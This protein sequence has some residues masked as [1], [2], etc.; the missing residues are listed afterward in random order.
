MLKRGSDYGQFLE[1]LGARKGPEVCDAARRILDSVTTL[2]PDV[3]MPSIDPTLDLSQ[4]DVCLLTDGKPRLFRISEKGVL[5][6]YMREQKNAG[7][8]LPEYPEF[9]DASTLRDLEDRLLKIG[10]A[11]WGKDRTRITIS[12]LTQLD[13]AEMT[14][15]LAAIRWMID[16]FTEALV[17]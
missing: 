2:S 4:Q 5:T 15:L 13:D 14:K 12:D 7:R 8:T 16:R 9:K 3:F 11:A 10:P 1:R 6:F 17:P